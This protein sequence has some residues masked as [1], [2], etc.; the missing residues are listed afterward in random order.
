MRETLVTRS[1]VLCATV[2][3]SSSQKHFQELKKRFKKHHRKAAKKFADAGDLAVRTAAAGALAGTLALTGPLP[4][5]GNT[6]ITV[7]TSTLTPAKEVHPEMPEVPKS[8]A[9]YRKKNLAQQL[10][11]VLPSRVGPLSEKVEAE[12]GRILH[13][14]LNINA[15]A[16]LKNFRLN[17]SYGYIGAEQHL[18]RFPGDSATQHGGWASS[19]ITRTLGAWGYVP[20][21]F[22]AY[23]FAVQTFVSPMWQKNY[24]LTY[25]W[26]KWRKMVAVNPKT[27]EA[28]IGVVADAGPAVWTGKQF[29]GSPEV[30]EALGLHKGPRKGEVILFFVDDIEN[31]VPLGPVN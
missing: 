30:M 11:Q 28:V 7:S 4:K 13:E 17:T 9:A 19:G 27:G 22:E 18:P 10:M 20:D 21:H 16:Q 3:K 29:G 12:V 5:D 8:R 6:N 23:Y 14:Y 2:S 15:K 24:Q 26:F 31:K 1:L 25:D